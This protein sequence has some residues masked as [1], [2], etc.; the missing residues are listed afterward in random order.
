MDV[1]HYLRRSLGLIS[2]QKCPK[3]HF[4]LKVHLR[5]NF[6]LLKSIVMSDF[7]RQIN[8][9]EFRCTVYPELIPEKRDCKDTV[10]YTL[11]IIEELLIYK[12]NHHH[13][14]VFGDSLTVPNQY[15]PYEYGKSMD[16][17]LVML[18]SWHTMHR[19]TNNGQI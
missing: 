12:V 19:G 9:L 14:I 13:V 8:V 10:L 5:L 17:L 18:G 16:W 11:N 3:L 6:S 1:T 4:H 2:R 7:V 15:F